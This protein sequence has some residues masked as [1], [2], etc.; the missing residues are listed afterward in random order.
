MKTQVIQIDSLDD[1][2]S[3]RDKMQWV[4][5]P[6]LLLV[7]PRKGPARIGK[8]DLKILQRNAGRLGFQL[9]LMTR[10]RKILRAAEELSI[11]HFAGFLEAQKKVW[12]SQ[13]P[14]IRKNQRIPR[15]RFRKIRSS[16]FPDTARAETSIGYR[17]LFITL[18]I[19]AILAVLSIFIP[20]ASIYLSPQPQSQTV[21]IFLTANPEISA[22]NSAYAIP[23]RS[24]TIPVSGSREI[25]I[26]S[27]ALVPD[28]FAH[29]EAQFS[30]LTL[31][32]VGIPKGT[33][34]RTI[35]SPTIRFAT[36][37]DGVLEG[38][39]GKTIDIPIIALE[40]GSEGNVP[41]NSLIVVEGSLGLSV[42]ST[43]PGPITGGTNKSLII[44]TMEDRVRL[45]ELLLT[46]LHTQA[47]EQI[48]KMVGEGS[49]VFP[50]TVIPE[51][52]LKENYQPSEGQPGNK[53]VL[54][55]TGN[56]HGLYVSA[57]DINSVETAVLNA[58]LPDGFET[59]PGSNGSDTSGGI[60]TG[61]DGVSHWSVTATRLIRPKLDSFL[62][63]LLVRGLKID[64][65]EK[66]I[67]NKYRLNSS[68]E[69]EISPSFW[70][71]LPFTILRI[72]IVIK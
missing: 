60:I 24:V 36:L 56:F 53:L 7:F 52:E 67:T 39:V 71:W 62:V 30:N 47:V 35:G 70:P 6:R 19:L 2:V 72:N 58:G 37:Q 1:V 69:I 32:E 57:K 49:I 64:T 33:V 9:G 17:L 18:S 8:L 63:A 29:G 31:T 54:T 14:V 4:K 61:D 42:S 26:I 44:P 23:A 13:D 48:S 38:E 51:G 10:N 45:K 50:A 27:T 25:T 5:A 3:I 41:A 34:I 16:L 68:P 59:M 20:S 22:M 40:P 15:N 65:A 11:P 55:I 46:D 66:A 28:K 21:T 12:V 43:N